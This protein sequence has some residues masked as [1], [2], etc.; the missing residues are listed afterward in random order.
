[1]IGLIRRV[2]FDERGLIREELLYHYI[3]DVIGLIGRVVFD[4]RGLIRGGLLYIDFS[5][6]RRPL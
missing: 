5:P 1:V 3:T 6:E 2:A 4:E